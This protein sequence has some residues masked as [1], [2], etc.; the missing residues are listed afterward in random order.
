MVK[1]RL[2]TRSFLL[3]STMNFFV[4]LVYYL[5]MVIIAGYAMKRLNA[6]PSQA[7]LAVGIFIVGALIS[8]IYAGSAIDRVGWKRMFYIG[9]SVYL[10]ATALYFNA[11]SLLFLS[12]TRFLHGIGF[13]IAS[14]ATGTVAAGI[15]PSERRG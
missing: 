15:I 2:W 8:R 7:G 6:S 1:P 3:V 11:S 13:G 10:V 4:Y 12:V 5:L 9:L 14:I